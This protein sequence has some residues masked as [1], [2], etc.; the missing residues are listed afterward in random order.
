MVAGPELAPGT[1]VRDLHA[2][3]LRRGTAPECGI[4]SARPAGCRVRRLAGECCAGQYV[5]ALRNGLGS[6]DRRGRGLRLRR[7]GLFRLAWL[8]ARMAGADPFLRALLC[9]TKEAQSV[10]PGP[11]LEVRA[12]TDFSLD[13]IPA[14][15][16]HEPRSTRAK[17]RPGQR[18][19][20]ANASWLRGAA[21][22]LAL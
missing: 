8:L 10:A 11:R 22:P 7:R 17:S 18:R 5:S 12:R 20:L 3:Y 13:G 19:A 9:P 4:A 1:R 2:A 21:V 14:P 6:L 15:F 16:S